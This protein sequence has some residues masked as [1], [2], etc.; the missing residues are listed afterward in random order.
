MDFGILGPVEVSTPS[1]VTRIASAKQR[2]LL[3]L[4][5]LQPNRTVSADRLVDEL[6]EGI[7]PASAA[8]SLRVLVSRLRKHLAE[9]DPQEVLVTRPP[10]YVLA[11]EPADVD[12]TRFEALVIRGRSLQ[13]AGDAEGAASVLRGAL[14]LWRGPALADVGELRAARA[15]AARLEELRLAALEDRIEADLATGRHGLLTAELEALTR[16]HPLRERLWGQRMLAL[17]RAGRQSD[18]LRAYQDLRRTLGEELGLSPS[19]AL[20]RLEAAI[21]QQDQ[22]AEWQP[23]ATDVP[24]GR[25]ADLPSGVVTFLLTDIE[26]STSLWESKPA[27][28]ADA[29]VLHDDLLRAV[30]AGN[31]GHLMRTRGEGDS[32]FSVFSRATD[33]IDAALDAQRALAAAAWPAGVRLR[34]RMALNTGETVERTGDYVG[35]TV[36]RTARLRGIALAGQIIVSQSTADLVVDHLHNAELLELGEHALR[37]LTRPERIYEVRRSSGDVATDV[38]V[39]STSPKLPAALARASTGVFVARSAE[40]ERLRGAWQAVLA[41]EPRLVLVAGEAGIGKSRLAA[42]LAR[43][44]SEAGALVLFGRCDEGAGPPYQPFA[45]ALRSCV[46]GMASNDLAAHVE[47]YGAGLANLIPEVARL[48]ST[49]AVFGL[50]DPETERARMFEAAGTLLADVSSRA[51]VLLVVDDLHWGGKGTMLLLR[52][53]ARTGDDLR[54]MVLV[55]YRDTDVSRDHPFGEALA[56]LRR[57]VTVE[58]VVLRG[59][60]EKA[61]TDFVTATGGQELEGDEI[62]FAVTLHAA[63]EG[64]PFFLQEVLRHLVDTG[65]VFR[66][67][68]RWHA[69]VLAIT[70]AGLPE[71]VR[72]VIGR[73]LG[74]LSEPT[75][76]M[77]V[78]AAVIGRHFSVR[79]LCAL[80]P[81][82][83]DAQVLDAIDE[84]VR[85]GIIAERLDVFAFSH[86][87]IRQTLYSEL[88]SARR[89]R[90]HRRVGEAIETLPDAH[91][92]ADELAYHFAEAALDGQ[93][94]KAAEYALDAASHAMQRVAYEEATS[95]LERGLQVLDLDGGDAPVATD[96]LLQLAEAKHAAGDPEG[97]R[98]TALEAAR[99]ARGH[100]Q[101]EHLAQLGVLLTQRSRAALP[102]PLHAA[103]CE[104]AL[105]SLGEEHPALRARAMAAL[106][107]YRATA[108]SQGPAEPLLQEAIAL[109]RTIEEPAV[110]AQVLA[111][112]LIIFAGWPQAEEARALSDELIS[113]ATAL[114]RGDQV[115]EGLLTRAQARLALGDIGGFVTDLDRLERDAIEQRSWIFEAL[116]GVMRASHALLEGRHSEVEALMSAYAARGGQDATV[117]TGYF[118]HRI[119]LMVA[120]GTPVELERLTHDAKAFRPELRVVD[121]I[122]ALA[123]AFQGRVEEAHDA[124]A[125]LLADD[126]AALTRDVQWSSSLRLCSEAVAVMGD[127]DL[128]A[129]VAP[130]LDPYAG[131]VIIT[132]AVAFYGAADLYRGMLAATVGDV[133]LSLELYDAALAL[134]EHIGAAPYVALTHLWHARSLR[135]RRAAGDVEAARRRATAAH[136]AALQ[137]SMPRLAAEAAEVL[138]GL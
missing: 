34:V 39:R 107:R 94:P 31:G 8:T 114:G 93:A 110:L 63:T 5:L 18:A 100:G 43:E 30:V 103:V 128:A 11:V 125:P 89:A 55:T 52:H 66:S 97:A 120:C 61:V 29:L 115:A 21:V 7:A 75:R 53:L 86:A 9:L 109:A 35:T 85:T 136:T 71:G 32:T 79:L 57:E 59:L 134:N 105:S 6:W 111:S 51:P 91:T 95:L 135:R 74:R 84:A 22:M 33:A 27:A 44:L 70:K 13:S 16:E 24:S 45:E 37:G 116:A 106:G 54:V 40:L 78:T 68:G 2:A 77:L 90:L 137:L 65:A 76:T 20:E 41:G 36:N 102:D 88:S 49:P 15:A 58:R 119:Q 42:E 113:I 87:L 122:L 4:L 129:T 10:G 92:R 80:A 121:A 99:I 98:T 123:L 28:M 56:D 138:R 72:D 127:T 130:H 131:E 14:E 126:M 48:G 108:E 104:D 81:G 60:D 46:L 82:E 112:V 19:P 101:W 23:V 67:D 26:G 133:D 73:R 25:A 118:A 1:G 124:L 50:T 83:D 132:N 38:A 12:A 47:S 96:L 17:Y 64:N 117:A 3:A 69:D 62:D